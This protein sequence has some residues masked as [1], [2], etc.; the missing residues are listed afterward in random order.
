MSDRKKL[1]QILSASFD[2]DPEGWDKKEYEVISEIKSDYEK[3]ITKQEMY[4][5]KELLPHQRSIESI[6]YDLRVV[7]LKVLE[8]TLNKQNPVPYILSENKTQFSFCLIIIILGIL[9]LLISNIMS[10]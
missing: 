5:S 9:L 4:Q 3:E 6:V 1:N 2:P 7:F 10:N 8:I